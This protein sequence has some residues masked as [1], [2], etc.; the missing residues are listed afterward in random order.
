MSKQISLFSGYSHHE[1]RTT[2]Y[3]LLILK[4]V[5]EENP[6]FLGEVLGAVVGE[7]LGERIG[8]KFRQQERKKASTPDGLITQPAFT[9]YVETK[10]FDWFYEEQLENHLEALEQE[11]SGLKV[12]IALAK[13]DETTSDRFDRI[14]VL[15]REK[16]KG[17]IL[18]KEVTFEELTRALQLSHLPKNLADAVIDFRAYLDEQDLL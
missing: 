9:I 10:N 12:L 8:V 16:Y 2:N 4:M 17:K 18:F 1:N 5:Y 6:K 11:E 13:F 15:C 3:C 14:K 7:G